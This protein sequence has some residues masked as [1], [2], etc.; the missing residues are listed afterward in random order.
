MANIKFEKTEI[1]KFTVK[2]TLSEDGKTISY[3]ND[4][5]VE[6]EI[7]LTKC[8]ET[9]GGGEINLSITNKTT[10]DLSEGE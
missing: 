5:K 2:G 3:L 4:D 9:F 6:V 10:E 1:K 7:P 8:F